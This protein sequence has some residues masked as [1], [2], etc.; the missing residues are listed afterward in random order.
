MLAQSLLA[1]VGTELPLRQGEFT[2]QY[3]SRYRWSLRVTPIGDTQDFRELPVGAYTIVAEVFWGD[4]MQERSIALQTLR[5][6][7]K[8][9]RR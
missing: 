8:D 1:R 7:P 2:S 3:S 6:G 5:I 4:G 9:A